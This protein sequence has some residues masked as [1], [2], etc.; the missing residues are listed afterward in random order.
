MNK[1]C[2]NSNSSQPE[3]LSLLQQAFSECR[4]GLFFFVLSAVLFYF[5][6]ILYNFDQPAEPV[7]LYLLLMIP[8]IILWILRKIVRL[9]RMQERIAEGKLDPEYYPKS[10][11]PLLNETER[12]RRENSR[13]I[14][15]NQRRNQESQDYFTLW[16]HET[17]LPIAAMD[18]L[19]QTEN[20]SIPLLQEQTRR[21]SHSVEMAMAYIRLEN[22]DYRMETI[23]LEDLIRPILRSSAAL[24]NGKHLK[25]QFEPSSAVV[26]TD[27]KWARFILEQLLSNAVK[28][29]PQGK[30][31]SILCK[32]NGIEILDEG[33]GI[34]RQDFPRIFEK[35]YTGK[36]GH[37]NS[38]ASSG[39]GLYL[40]K[41]TAEAIGCSLQL[42]NRI[43][44]PGLQA[45][46]FFT[47][48]PDH[49]PD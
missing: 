38:A 49:L 29:S 12:L 6:L 8:L 1:L 11:E 16:A 4:A 48:D 30:T 15:E 34:S 13:I 3:I 47:A 44:K 10:M 35:G 18:L 45:A 36:N 32:E 24:F 41:K 46:V 5:L 27:Q 26:L 23:S 14:L 21:L 37:E 43:E 17:K 28:Y 9:N 19:L 42:K 31:I 2:R 7:L 25:L 33:P 20:P 40:S 39:M 22:S